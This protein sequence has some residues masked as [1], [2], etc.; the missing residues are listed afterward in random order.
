MT[1]CPA[2][3]PNG[4]GGCATGQTSCSATCTDTTRDASNCGACGTVCASG[5]VCVA[6]VCAAD[7]RLSC[8]DSTQ[9]I[10]S[11][12]CVSLKTDLKNCGTCGTTCTGNLTCIAGLCVDP[13]APKVTCKSGLLSSCVDLTS[14]AT[15][16]GACGT[17]CTTGQQCSSGACACPS[18]I[19][20]TC[21]TGSSATCVNLQSDGAN[22][23]TCGHACGSGNLCASGTCVISCPSATPTTCP[24]VS[25]TYCANLPTDIANCGAC[26]NACATGGSCAS[27]TCSCPAGLHAGICGGACVD[28]FSDPM[29]C[30][31]CATACNVANGQ[32]CV[33]ATCICPATASDICI[34][35]CVNKQ[36]DPNNC[37]VCGT[38]CTGPTP[39]CGGGMCVA[40][41]TS[42][43][44]LLTSTP[45]AT[46]SVY[47][48]LPTGASTVFPAY[49]DMT[50]DGGGWT[51]FYG[52]LNG[53]PN[54]FDH[55]ESTA[56]DC[57]DP[58][59]HC[60]RRIP[61]GLP[62]S[63]YFQASCGSAAVKFQAPTAVFSLFASG[64][65][66]S[67]QT[68]SNVVS[69]A[70][71]AVVADVKYL[72]TG[73]VNNLSWI[74]SSSNNS[75]T[76]A[77]FASGYNQNT[78]W[79]YCNGVADTASATKL[80][81][82][83]PCPAICSGICVNTQ[84]DA[85]N[86]GSCGNVCPCDQ[87][88]SAGSCSANSASGLVGYWKFD[89]GSGTTFADAS[90]SGH[91]GT[92]A[93]AQIWVPG[94]QGSALLFGG[95][96]APNASVPNLDMNVWSYSAWIKRAAVS[97]SSDK[98]VLGSHNT[99][100]WGIGFH[101]DN[102]ILQTKIGVNAHY[103]T[104][105]VA[106]TAFHHIAVTYSGTQVCFYLD[107]T[108]DNCVAATDTFSSSAGV[109]DVGG[110]NNTAVYFPGL[111]DEMRVYSRVLAAQE[112]T[113]L[114]GSTCP[115]AAPA[116]CGGAR[117][118]TL[119]YAQ[120]HC[121]DC[122]TTC[123]G[124]TPYCIGGSC[125]A[126]GSATFSYTGGNQSFVV[127]TGLTTVDVKMWGGAGGRGVGQ[128][129]N[130]QPGGAGGY[131]SAT[132]SV[133]PGETLNVLVGGGGLGAASTGTNGSWF[134]P[135]GGG[136]PDGGGRTSNA[137]GAGGGR[138]EIKR[139]TSDLLIAGGGGG[140]GTNLSTDNISLGG[141]GGGA[142]GA[143]G[144]NSNNEHGGSGGSQSAGGAAGTGVHS[145]AS[146]AAF[147]GGQL[148]TS[149]SFGTCGGGGGYYGGG[150]G[151]N[152]YGSNDDGAGCGGGSGYT[153]TTGVTSPVTTV[154]TGTTPA[155]NSDTAYVTG[156]AVGGG[157]STANGGNGLVIIS[158]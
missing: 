40:A 98:V 47:Y 124:G 152:A 25:P 82:R 36:T 128:N 78:T 132:L 58:Q 68:L 20:N 134:S 70:G 108:F 105:S 59:N 130:N 113:L 26:G 106:D 121:G 50:T 154:G 95:I 153:T 157:A 131:T 69:L 16:C 12:T 125:A 49:C 118:A 103:S 66:S 53:S 28:L 83:E 31:D 127:P 143:S 116:Y 146:G 79:N 90:G 4:G 155:N 100:G 133:T 60:V 9:S 151:S 33:N 11:G 7:P 46:S 99:G 51:E 45:A 54:V 10:C 1:G 8:D 22:C 123:S 27:G 76:A 97:A 44:A 145:G 39:Y 67:W 32:A 71:A 122:A 23:G 104:H 129:G 65:Q 21:G 117:F 94:Y 57:T 29:H 102:T 15:N 93:T 42:C 55:F 85:N 30:S 75:S 135:I 14:D 61:A 43:A 6:S 149:M 101:S 139:G 115:G 84:G 156:T 110:T 73:G 35:K 64:A 111:I 89:E 92:L 142:S 72:F 19:P 112:V 77:T 109:Y 158:F 136:F 88:C 62:I 3:N 41:S 141:A 74:I 147:Q 91:A 13:C 37:G 18:S 17:K 150:T 24:V 120:N 138:S 140:G 38:M 96:T 34:G 114:Y 48:L 119:S 107:G 52:A 63:T 148:S 86:C 137:N 144:G 56:A 5:M 80:F 2:P 87:G 81:Y 126:H